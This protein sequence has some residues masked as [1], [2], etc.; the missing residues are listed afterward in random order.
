M[1]C[2]GGNLGIWGWE[3]AEGHVKIDDLRVKTKCCQK[4]IH[5]IG[6]VR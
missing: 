3:G 6:E 4:G 2:E 1:V 5:E